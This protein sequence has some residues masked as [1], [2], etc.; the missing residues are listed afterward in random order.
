MFMYTYMIEYVCINTNENYGI[1]RLLIKKYIYNI[2][3][4][5][6]AYK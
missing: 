3:D 1:T 6:V 5:R 4:S 2:C